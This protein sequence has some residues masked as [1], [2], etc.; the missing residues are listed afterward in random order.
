MEYNMN[1]SDKVMIC[2]GCM[3]QTAGASGCPCG[4]HYDYN[5]AEREELLA[6]GTLLNGGQ[7]LVGRRLGRGGFGITYLGRRQDELGMKVA[8]K[9][10]FP[11]KLVQR[12]MSRSASLYALSEGAEKRFRLGKGEFLEEAKRLAAFAELP[13]IVSVLG[14]FEENDTA[15]I[16]MEYVDGID[17][18]AFMRQMGRTLTV[19]EVKRFILPVAEDLHRVHQEGMVHRD[20]SPDNIMVSRNGRVKLIDFG[21]TVSQGEDEEVKVLRKNGF[22]PPEQYEPSGEHLGPWTDVYALCATIYMLLSGKILPDARDRQQADSYRTLRSMDIY[23][24]RKLDRI[25]KRGLCMDP[26]RRCQSMR[27]LAGQLRKVPVGKRLNGWLAP[28][29]GLAVCL[30]ICGWEYLTLYLWKPQIRQTV[31]EAAALSRMEG[32]SG[33]E[34]PAGVCAASA[35]AY[36]VY[37]GLVYI[38]Y[39]FEDGVVMLM[40]SP[41][42]TDDFSQVEYVTDGAFGSFCVYEG[43]LYLTG[44]SDHCI[45]RVGLETLAALEDSERRLEALEKAGYLEKIS[46][47]LEGMR[48]GFYIEEGYLYA[49]TGQGEFCEIRRMSVDGGEQYGT[50]LGL[51]LTNVVFHEGFF[52]Y[53][54]REGGESVIGRLRL[55]GCYY[56]ELSRY[57]GD[58]PAVAL[59]GGSLYY[60]LNGGEE[61]Y[62]GCIGLNGVEDRVLV[63]KNNADLD[64]CYLTGIVDEDYIYYTCSMEGSEMLNSLYCY[65]LSENS[66]KQI[67]SECGRY[68]ATSDEIPYLIFASVD[69]SEIRQMNKDGS[70]PRVMRDADGGTGILDS[71]DITSLEIIRNHVYYLDGENVAYKEIVAEEL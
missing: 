28:A 21:A 26:D 37:D 55:D 41:V 1:G 47:A 38:R 63:R 58:I 24:P 29:V 40:R 10:Y 14:Y 69:G 7:Y 18:Q 9:E 30:G 68:I 31:T 6:P 45:Y 62:L 70:N 32:E 25:L 20:I 60:L 65:S 48:Y 22:A 57:A 43:Y 11:R 5:A 42:G 39:V 13:A 16:V 49:V 61:S 2:Y 51:R 53:T 66:N 8:V 4:W 52:Y 19:S 50:S 34:A 67:S 15:Y 46:D 71:V 54:A 12:H 23:V 33:Q 27:E 59:S 35:E 44:L 64:Y 3:R 36:A 56:Q 17:L